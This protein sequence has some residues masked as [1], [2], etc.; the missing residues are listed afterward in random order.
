[1]IHELFPEYF[2]P[3]DLTPY[4]KRKVIEEA[5]HIIAISESTK[6]DLMRL[7]RVPEDKISVIYHGLFEPTIYLNQ[8]DEV[9]IKVNSEKQYVLYVGERG[10]YKNFYRFILAIESIMKRH[11][12]LHVVCAGGGSF[13]SAELEYLTRLNISDRV[14]QMTVDE[15][16]LKKL[17]KDA[18]FFCYPSLYEGFGLPI[19]E[20]FAYGCPVVVSNTSC[21]AEVGGNAA[22][23]FNPYHIDDMIDAFQ[24]VIESSNL[25]TALIAAGSERLKLFSIESCLEKTVEVYRKSKG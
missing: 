20:A 25:R 24:S 4:F 8:D 23:Y 13:G 19:L 17:Y 2:S 22:K 14:V 15:L 9:G 16:K 7:M 3:T 1:M 12:N 21:F 5:R 11:T 6:N 10:A 18:L